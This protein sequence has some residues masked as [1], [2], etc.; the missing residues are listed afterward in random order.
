MKEGSTGCTIGSSSTDHCASNKCDVTIGGKTYCSQCATG[1]VPID[2]TC[3]DISGDTSKC[4]TNSNGACTQCGP[5]Y[6]LHKGGCY[7]FGGEVGSIICTD[8]STSDGSPAAGACTTCAS[9]YFKNPTQAAAAVPRA[10][11]AT[12]R[13]V[14]VQIRGSL[15]V[16]LVRLPVH[17]G[18]LHA[19]RAWRAS[20]GTPVARSVQI[21]IVPNARKQARRSALS[22]KPLGTKST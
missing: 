17:L 4:T 20:S 3:T 8:P 6:F 9:G 5:G 2:G 1:Y 14:M 12:T 18:L 21:P 22:V 7:K 10:S 19:K 13:L 11:H 15:D 16:P